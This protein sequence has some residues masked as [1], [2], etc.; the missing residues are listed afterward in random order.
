MKVAIISPDEKSEKGISTYS[1]DLANTMIKYGIEVDLLHYK[2]GSFISFSKNIPKVRKYDIV[3]VQHEFGLFGMTGLMFIPA[4]LL[5]ALCKRGKIVTTMHTVYKKDEK[6][7]Y[8]PLL[9]KFKRA[10]VNNLHYKLI[11][12]FSA[13]IITHTD[14]LRSDLHEV[15]NVPNEKISVIP[16]GVVNNPRFDKK[17]SKKKLGIS[18]PLY[19][20]IG[21]VVPAKG[22]DVVV[23]QAKKIGK[24]IV[25]AGDAPGVVKAKYVESLK[26]YVKIN[27][28]ENIVKFYI[29][30]SFNARQD[31][32][33]TYFSA[34][35]IILLP[36]K[37]MTTSGI[38]INAMESRR[39]V[40]GSD[41]R[42]FLEIASKYGCIKTVKRDE[43]YPKAVKAAMKNLKKMES[44]AD[45]F[46][47]DNS[48][49]S[50]AK[51]T[52][53]LYKSVLSKDNI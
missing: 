42:Y 3:H 47:K 53:G 5:L 50:I 30:D 8:Y 27:H 33:W 48:L 20:A 10:I 23:E 12:L 37:K 46:A 21:H 18:G 25:I 22:F 34:A 28:L 39:P 51:K 43:D 2:S 7:M 52:I 9:G 16:Q 29:S 44:E 26:E 31:L 6:L 41:S 45:R 49:D 36:Y 38:F 24:T 4:M 17:K 1:T 11:K 19:L 13:A 15:A 40:I 32:W 14:F 35:D